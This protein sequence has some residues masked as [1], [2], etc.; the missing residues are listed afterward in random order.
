VLS[1]LLLEFYRRIRIVMTKYITDNEVT[2]QQVMRF[3]D[4]PDVDEVTLRRLDGDKVRSAS[5]NASI[6]KYCDLLA[7]E[8]NSRDM[9]MMLVLESQAAVPWT[10]ESVKEYQWR[11]IQIAMGFNESTTKL[12]TAQ[13]NK[14]YERLN[15][16][17]ASTWGIAVS[18]PSVESMR[19]DSL[20]MR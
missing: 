16:H 3:I 18:F 4:S 14:V 7:N 15:G 8:Y 5:Q 1:V 20:V 13:V 6:H 2:K 12:E 17:T 9:D 19:R 11:K 10:M